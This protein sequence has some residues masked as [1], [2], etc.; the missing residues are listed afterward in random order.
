[1]ADRHFATVPQSSTASSNDCLP[2]IALT[3]GALD[4]E[5]MRASVAGM[6]DFLTKP[7]EPRYVVKP[8]RSKIGFFIG[9]PRGQGDDISPTSPQ[10]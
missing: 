8:L 7:L 4:S 10:C 6:D 5:R 9:K 1:M 2:V 3:A